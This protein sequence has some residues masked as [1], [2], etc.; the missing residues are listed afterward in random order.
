MDYG[1]FD[2]KYDI[3]PR[4]SDLFSTPHIVYI[5]AVFLLGTLAAFMLRK[6]SREKITRF[7]KVM[8]VFSVVLEITKITW[9]SAYDISRGF[10]FNFGGILPIY[11]CSLFIYTLIFAAWT[12]GRARDVSLAFLS[13]IGM[14]FGGIG[15]VYCNGLN[16]YPFFTFGAFYSLYFH[17]AMFITGMIL[18]FTGYKKLSW[19]DVYRS[20][21]P[22]CLL[23]VVAI[24]VNYILGSD[25]MLLYSAGGVPL[26]EDLA[27]FLAG[28]GL[29][30]IFTGIMLLTHLPL[31]ALIVGLYKLIAPAVRKTKNVT[32]GSAAKEV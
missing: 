13:T 24:P 2:Y 30:F 10:G 21:I 11:S 20:F 14:L 29:R 12:R 31:S 27:S 15:V 6:T 16:F 25:Y 23:S 26:Y 8:S 3:P 19:R 17:S 22:I 9:E 1:F 5:A 4:P 18:L 7:L 32:P 28:K